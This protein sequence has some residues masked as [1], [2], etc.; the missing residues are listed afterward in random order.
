VVTRGN[1]ESGISGVGGGAEEPKP[2]PRR[3]FPEKPEKA[4]NS[5]G[6]IANTA[7]RRPESARPQTSLNS[8]SSSVA[9]LARDATTKQSLAHAPATAATASTAAPP[10]APPAAAPLRADGEVRRV[11]KVQALTEQSQVP[12]AI[13]MQAPRGGAAP[14]APVPTAAPAEQRISAEETKKVSVLQ[15]ANNF[16]QKAEEGSPQ[17]PPPERPTIKWL[18]TDKVFKVNGNTITKASAW[19]ASGSDASG[20]EEYGVA[21]ADVALSSGVHGSLRSIS[22]LCR[23]PCVLYLVCAVPHVP[24]SCALP[25]ASIRSLRCLVCL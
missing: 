7:G 6:E 23:L 15:M 16:A 19:S 20:S 24:L 18:T 17:M 1:G 3:S 12:A 11:M 9:G 13:P 14:A 5:A 10:L 21:I 25:H 4:A 22:S 2:P 8:D